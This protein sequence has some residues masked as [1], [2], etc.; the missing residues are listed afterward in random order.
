[1]IEALND[2]RFTEGEWSRLLREYLAPAGDDVVDKARRLQKDWYYSLTLDQGRRI[3]GSDVKNIYIIDKQDLGRNSLQVINQYTAEGSHQNRYDV[4]VLI[5]GLPLVHVEL[6]KR[7]VDLT[8]AFNQIKRYKRESFWSGCG[9]YE[10]AQIFIIS[11]GTLT[12]YYSNTT[13][14]QHISGG[15]AGAAGSSFK[16]TSFWADRTNNPIKDLMDFTA[17]FMQP[18]TLLSVL[19]RY[20]IL[21]VKDE[22][23]V[24]RPYQIC[25]SEA[26]LNKIN[27][28]YREDLYGDR[29]WT[30]DLRAQAA[31]DPGNAPDKKSGGY[32]WHATG[33]GKTLTSFHTARAAVGLPFID[34]VL[35]VVDR[36]D[37]DYQTMQEY[38]KFQQGAADG[39]DNTAALKEKLDKDSDKIIVTTIQKLTRFIKTNPQ[40]KVYGRHIVIIFDE[41]HRSHFGEMHKLITSHFKNY[42][43]FGFTGTPIIRP[44]GADPEGMTTALQF[45]AKLHAYTINDAINDE[46]VLPFKVDYIKTV[47]KHVEDLTDVEVQGID[48]Q[49]AW[50]ANWRM[51]MISNDIIANYATKTRKRRFNAILATDG[52]KSC[53]IYY[54]MLKK[55]AAEQG[56]PLKIAAIFSFE[57]NPDEDDYDD[58]GDISTTNLDVTPREFLDNEA[59]SDYNC[60]FGTDFSTDRGRFDSYYKDISRRMKNREIDLLVVCDMFLT[61]FDAKCLNTMWID[62]KLYMHKVIQTFSRTNRIWDSNKPFGN[63]IC[64]RN[65]T[66]EVEEAVACYS[67]PDSEVSILIRP[68]GD[69]YASY[70]E[71]CSRMRSDFPLPLRAIMTNEAKKEFVSL[72]SSIRR[73]MVTLS[74]FEE[75]EGKALLTQGELQDYQSE[76][77]DIYRSLREQKE[78]PADIGDDLVFELEILRHDDIDI[79]YIM[80]LIRQLGA[81]ENKNRELKANIE[82]QIKA[83]PLLK[84]KLE[85]INKFIAELSNKGCSPEAWRE[86]VEE[87]REQ[88]L[89]RIIREERLNEERTRLL[90]EEA[91]LS[92]YINTQGPDIGNLLPPLPIFGGAREKAME[93]VISSL[94]E[95]ME[96]YY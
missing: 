63:I 14:Q 54:R 9:L 35:F 57:A 71:A 74:A 8:Q 31:L 83:S 69:Y 58:L 15:G 38:D 80:G 41:C 94:T 5:N 17:T 76:Y 50:E 18:Q 4:T 19:T 84:S 72:F 26:V 2:I 32:I 47:K 52:V 81:D 92:G 48:R 66:H 75:F 24:M 90:I 89:A 1:Q 42:Y 82:R 30:E 88:A 11:N 96:M 68:F 62:K 79:S 28:A 61:G 7:G 85:L 64:Y 77:L 78:D 29:Q 34:K 10:Y 13:R 20:C 33:S 12:K 40:D 25:A 49:S 22:L 46:N 45:G 70:A 91:L 67:N 43:I 86:F 53:I 93:R 3:G 51:A 56:V 6:K 23:M 73:L 60:M 59:I 27:K 21:T 87:E 36:K 16:F 37:L 55:Y 44:A 39:T 65:L 95:Y